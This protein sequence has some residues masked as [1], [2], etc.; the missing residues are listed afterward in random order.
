MGSLVS[1]NK[2]SSREHGEVRFSQPTGI[3]PNFYW[4]QSVVRNLIAAKRI[5]PMRPG[6]EE[7]SSGQD[8]ECPICFLYFPPGLNR[9]VCCRQSVCSECYLQIRRPNQPAECPFCMNERWRVA[10]TGPKSAEQLAR[11]HHEQ[12]K[13]RLLEEKIRRDEIER[14]Q[15][16]TELL[17]LKL[18]Q[19]DPP[20][21]TTPTSADHPSADN[22]AAAEHSMSTAAQPTA[23]EEERKSDAAAA[24]ARNHAD[25]DNEPPPDLHAPSSASAVAAPAPAPAP[26]SAPAPAPAPAQSE[27]TDSV[28]HATTLSVHPSAADEPHSTVPTTSPAMDQE[29]MFEDLMVA[30]AIRLSLA[31]L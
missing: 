7:P 19:V 27:V 28:P 26:A 2:E 6:T 13:V 8:E 17:R 11:E 24:E 5:A 9:S 1:K 31:Q 4:N 16:R 30:E 3:Y 20:R 12:E 10:F 25:T 22:N 18:E 29:Q 21:R 14:D 23:E 15:K